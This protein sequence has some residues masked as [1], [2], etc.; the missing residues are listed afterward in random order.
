MDTKHPEKPSKQALWLQDKQARLAARQAAQ[1]SENAAPPAPVKNKVLGSV[2]VSEHWKGL[3]AVLL[4]VSCAIF[5]VYV[6]FRDTSDTSVL[7]VTASRGLAED[8]PVVAALRQELERHCADVNRDGK[9]SVWMDVLDY[10]TPPSADA[11]QPADAA[12][13]ARLYG[14]LEKGASQLILLEDSLYERYRDQ[15]VFAELHALLPQRDFPLTDAL[16]VSETVLATVP[17][18]IP[19]GGLPA[20]VSEAAYYDG[21]RDVLDHLYIVFRAETDA[22]PE[23]RAVQLAL[24]ES[25]LNASPADRDPK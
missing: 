25:L 13:E 10:F 17:V 24:L 16:P 23:R 12:A 3:L 4:L 15:Q 11:P 22:Q 2:F 9:R 19:D 5:W 8:T 1:T 14:E 21:V 20:G 6:V 18:G 7:L